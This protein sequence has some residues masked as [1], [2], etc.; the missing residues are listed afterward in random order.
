MREQAE[1][2]IP[3]T[4]SCDMFPQTA[5]DPDFFH[6]RSFRAKG[7]LQT[8]QAAIDFSLRALVALAW[9]NTIFAGVCALSA[10]TGF[11]QFA[12]GAFAAVVSMA[13]S[14]FYILLLGVTGIMPPPK[15]L[16]G[17]YY[18]GG[19]VS[20]IQMELLRAVPIL[21]AVASLILLGW[22]IAGMAGVVL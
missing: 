17:G 9:V 21:P 12:W 19:R 8:N 6:D 4:I 5:E 3:D 16:R 1:S 11:P 10:G 13:L 2:Q 15:D 14:Y 22:G 18:F 7:F 20:A